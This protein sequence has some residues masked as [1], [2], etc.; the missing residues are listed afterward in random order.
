MSEPIVE[1]I[2]EWLVGAVAEITEAN[3]YHQD[4]AV[5]RPGDLEAADTAVADLTTVVGLEDA[6][7]GSRATREHRNW[8]QP[9]GII[10]FFVGTGG[11]DL[12]IDKRINRVRADIERRM[13]VEIAGYRGAKTL[14]NNLADAIE[15]RPPQI[16]L[17]EES[18]ATVL[19]CRVAIGYHVDYTNP[20]IQS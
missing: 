17:D 9:F 14:C 1:R 12:S 4:L 10:T 6:E 18:Q 5:V 11:T 3:G 15:I 16:W 2:A 13:G 7:V 8:V 20:Y 19:L